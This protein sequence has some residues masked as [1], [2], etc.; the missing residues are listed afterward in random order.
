MPKT[1]MVFHNSFFTKT[2]KPS[3]IGTNWA[4]PPQDQDFLPHLVLPWEGLRLLLWLS[5]NHVPSWVFW[6][7][8]GSVVVHGGEGDTKLPL[9]DL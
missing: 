6:F 8:Q 9:S 3:P 4:H 1:L 2:S 7:H 5:L